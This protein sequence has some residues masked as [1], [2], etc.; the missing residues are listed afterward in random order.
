MHNI[1]IFSVSEL[2]FSEVL[3]ADQYL[4]RD[5]PAPSRRIVAASPER[6]VRLLRHEGDRWSGAELVAARDAFGAPRQMGMGLVAGPESSDGLRISYVFPGSPAHAAGVRRGDL[7][8]AIDGIAIDALGAGSPAGAPREPDVT[9]LDL[10]SPG[11]ELREVTIK[12]ADHARPVI[13]VEKV[14]EAEGRRVGYVLLQH[15]VG[16]ASA[17]FLNAAARLRE[18]GVNEL[19]LDLRMNSGGSLHFS[20]VIA[21]A[22]AGPRLDGQTFQRLVHNDRY[23]DRDEDV[24]FGAPARG[25]LSLPRLIVITSEDTCSASEALIN[26][27]APHIAVVMVGTT[28]CG[29]PVGMTVVEYGERAYSVIT[30]RVLNARGEGDYYAG[31]RPTCQAED[32]FAHDLGDPAEASLSAAL[33]YIRFGRCPGRAASVPS[34][35]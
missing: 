18:Q 6:L 12:S 3:L 34:K 9:R 25:A 28:T 14:I 15:F 2:T 32:D 20:R 31:L 7:I 13:S 24:H 10:F 16:A 4:W 26:G 33:H 35:V 30:F 1:G 8:Q 22:I 17:E 23:R 27:L 19:V 29:K 21:S 5:D 11:R